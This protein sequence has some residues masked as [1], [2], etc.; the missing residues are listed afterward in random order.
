MARLKTQWEIKEPL[1]VRV[2]EALARVLVC[3]WRGHDRMTSFSGSLKACRRCG[4]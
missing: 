1:H 2:R 4:R 3:S